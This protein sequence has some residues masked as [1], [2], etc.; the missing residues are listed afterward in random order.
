M[1]GDT[2]ITQSRRSPYAR[3]SY[4]YECR[5]NVDAKWRGV[6]RLCNV[7]SSHSHSYSDPCKCMLSLGPRGMQCHLPVNDPEHS[8]ATGDYVLVP[9][10]SANVR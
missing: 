8:E 3:D 2:G 7:A 4:A 6:E 9:L 1:F 5:T 10:V